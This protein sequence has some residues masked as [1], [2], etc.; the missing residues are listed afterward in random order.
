MT[1]LRFQCDGRLLA[2]PLAIAILLHL[3][4][5][6]GSRDHLTIDSADYLAQAQSLV[7]H[8][9]ALNAAGQPDTVRTPGYPVFLTVFLATPLGI[10][11]AVAAQHLLWIGLVGATVCLAFRA[12]GNRVAAISAGVIAAIDLPGLQSGNTI[13]TETLAAACVLAAV[14][15]AFLLTER[16]QAA[17]TRLSAAAG[18]LAG[19]TALVRPVAVLLGVPLA[20][21]IAV[22]APRD[23]RMKAAIVVL[24]SSSVLP[25]LWTVR[26]YQRTGVATFSSIGGINLLKYRAAGTLAIR[27]AGGL[28][29]NFARRQAELEQ[30]A[31]A[32]LERIHSRPCVEIP[33]AIRASYYSS[34]AMPIILNDPLASLGQAARGLG[35]IVFGGGAVMIANL[36]GITESAARL[37]SLAYTVPLAIFAAVGC[38]FWWQRNRP[39]FWLLALVVGYMVGMSLGAEAYSRF[40]VPVLP[41]YAILAGG[42]IA[43]VMD[44]LRRRRLGMM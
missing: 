30:A 37:V 1:P 7:T 4:L 32:E 5:F 36:V 6:F 41:L 8:G 9:A 29:A 44:I 25:I 11:G 18:I 22:L 27:D 34:M 38:G 28:D 2:A 15:Q 40:R 20:M 35:M 13:L 10:R 14:W 24:V 42:G 33:M 31:C 16:D 17:S 12:S 26:N 43:S 39:F 3:A 23:V 19:V 21:A